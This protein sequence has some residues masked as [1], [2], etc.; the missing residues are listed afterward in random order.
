MS[1]KSSYLRYKGENNK[2]RRIIMKNRKKDLFL[3]GVVGI[4]V[5]AI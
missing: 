2:S 5:A 3:K 1:Q 4:L